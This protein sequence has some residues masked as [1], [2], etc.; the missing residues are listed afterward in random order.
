MRSLK[1]YEATLHQLGGRVAAYEE[2]LKRLSIDA[3]F[4][5]TDS[6]E[7]RS[8]LNI[9][10]GMEESWRERFQQGLATIVSRGL[11]AVF[12]EEISVRLET[13]TVRDAT[14]ITI[15]VEQNG[16]ETDVMDA[17]GGSLIQIM[18]FLLIVLLVVSSQPPLRRTVLLD[19]PFGMVSAQYFPAL[20]ELI[21]QLR[22]QLGIQFLMITHNMELLACAERAYVVE[23]EGDAARISELEVAG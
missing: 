14:S 6:E 19:E 13:T 2:E 4:A 11:T 8:I 1:A 15:K 16:F 18:S 12:N 21:K 7:L 17:K 9:L 23:L 5:A 22:T 20:C 10:Q 3:E